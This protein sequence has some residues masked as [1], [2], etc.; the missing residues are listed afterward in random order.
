MKDERTDRVLSGGSCYANIRRSC[1][2]EC[3]HGCYYSLDGKKGLTQE[4]S[5]PHCGIF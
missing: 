4:R 3:D 5:H 2:C 1:R